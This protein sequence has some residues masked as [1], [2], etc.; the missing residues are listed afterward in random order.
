MCRYQGL[1]IAA[2]SLSF[3][4]ASTRARSRSM[5]RKSI[6]SRVA[7][8]SSGDCGQ[9]DSSNSAA[10]FLLIS[11]QMSQMRSCSPGDRPSIAAWWK[12]ICRSRCQPGFNVASQ[13]S[14]VRSVDALVDGR[15]G[16]L[17]H[18][19]LL[20]VSGQERNCLNGGSARAD[21]RDALVAQLV[22]NRLALVP[23]GVVVIPSGGMEHLALEIFQSRHPGHLR[24]IDRS[25][26]HDDEPRSQIVA[27]I[28]CDT[29]PFD[30]LVPP[31]RV[32]ACVKQRPS[33]SSNFLATLWQYSRIS[34]PS[35][36]FFEGKNCISSSKRK[37]AVGVVVTGQA[38][39]SVPIPH[40]TEI[41]RLLD[42]SEIRH[43]GLS[44]VVAGENAG[45]TTTKYDDID[46]VA[47]GI[48]ATTESCAGR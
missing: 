6:T 33:Y 11:V 26:G 28:R 38:R 43:T 34:S 40:A 30:R 17:K 2:V 7:R 4:T 12:F 3:T 13:D 25:H 46:V 44:Q 5:T 20:G 27:A 22:E 35:A 37:I 19:E 1:R 8:N 45:P 24:C 21:D 36:N 32:D 10:R 39:V 23:A 41:A 9:P 16:A 47:E 42:D 48:G 31:Q 18:V 14:S 29:P 15:G